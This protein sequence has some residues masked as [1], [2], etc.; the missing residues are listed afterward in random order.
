MIKYQ[1]LHKSTIA[2]VSHVT[3]KDLLTIKRRWSTPP[4]Q[5]TL[6]NTHMLFTKQTIE[7]PLTHNSTIEN[8]MPNKWT[9][10]IIKATFRTRQLQ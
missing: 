4:V 3:T 10:I 7:S 8:N 1:S 2:P 9:E 6:I 5:R